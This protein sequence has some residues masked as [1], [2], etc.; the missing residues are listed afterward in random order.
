M[1]TSY[2]VN[3]TRPTLIRRHQIS[4]PE[5][6]RER[7]LR[8]VEY[9]PGRHRDLIAAGGTL[10]AMAACQAVRGRLPAPRTPEAVGPAARS[11]V[12]RASVLAGELWLE[13]PPA[14]GDTRSGH[15]KTRPI[16]VC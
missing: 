9:S 13:L 16:A 2:T 4:S 3:L 11:Q 6:R 7:G 8:I 15:T 14:L 5:P 10:P 12:L 1:I